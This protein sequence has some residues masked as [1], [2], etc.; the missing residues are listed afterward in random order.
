MMYDVI[1]CFGASAFNSITDV[2]CFIGVIVIL[3]AFMAG[4]VTLIGIWQKHMEAMTGK[5]AAE[6][7][8]K[9]TPTQK[10]IL[11]ASSPTVANNY[12]CVIDIWET[13]GSERDIEK[14]KMLF[15]SSW[16]EF[17][18][19]NARNSAEHFLTSGS[20]EI[21]RD[22]CTKDD[23]SELAADYTE[24]ERQMLDE[25]KRKYP[26]Q[27]MLAWDMVR[28]LSIVGEAYMG[29]IM[30]YDEA[31][32]TALSACR[33][34]QAN[35][36]SWDDMVGSYTLGYQL[37]RGKKSTDRLRYYKKLKRTWIYKI[38]WDTEL[39]ES[40]LGLGKIDFVNKFSE[41]DFFD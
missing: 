31:V 4:A 32:K 37:W 1:S 36:M 30:E 21:F 10:F 16:G 27:G 29:G 40:E 3:V 20:N 5:D 7:K 26:K 2:L 22:Y 35:F 39:K 12:K 11:A 6:M 18:Y 14:V 17:T 9:L 15:E 34:L 24:F 8:N 33:V 41:K 28:V 38:A 23:P 25:M 13:R 19:E